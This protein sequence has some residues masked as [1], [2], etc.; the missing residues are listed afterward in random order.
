MNAD[1]FHEDLWNI[2]SEPRNSCY[3][4]GKKLNGSDFVQSCEKFNIEL[5]ST[6]K[7]ILSETIFNH[8]EWMKLLENKSINEAMDKWK[9][10]HAFHCEN[11]DR[12]N[13][14]QQVFFAQVFL[15]ATFFHAALLRDFFGLLQLIKITIMQT[16]VI[17][18]TQVIFTVLFFTVLRN[19]E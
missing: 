10:L 8:D 11:I 19:R 13:T 4:L 2:Y 14:V 17:I 9:K 5:S 16:K 15:R 12:D 1:D 18:S 7:D 3:S 6:G